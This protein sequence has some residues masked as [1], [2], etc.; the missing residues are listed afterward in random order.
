MNAPGA[1]CVVVAMVA[2]CLGS[3]PGVQCRKKKMD[4][5]GELTLQQLFEQLSLGEKTPVRDSIE[6]NKEDNKIFF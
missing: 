4:L 6:Q 5:L 2:R 1:W 3:W